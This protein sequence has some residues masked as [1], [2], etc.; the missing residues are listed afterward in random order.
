MAFKTPAQIIGR[1]DSL[2]KEYI[3]PTPN[4]PFNSM[5]L[6][7]IK[8]MLDQVNDWSRSGMDEVKEA[9]GYASY[10][11]ALDGDYSEFERV[12]PVLR[13]YHAMQVEK[14]FHNTM[15]EINEWKNSGIQEYQNQA[16]LS[17]RQ[18]M[19][20]PALRLGMSIM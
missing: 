9:L 19:Y 16:D 20:N 14:T 2:K 3:T 10:E 4:K 11:K 13:N 6:R 1:F 18:C 5:D 12:H 17:L 15:V 8:D 7:E